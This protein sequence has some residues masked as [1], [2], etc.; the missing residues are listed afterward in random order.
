MT[1]AA[2]QPG[3]AAGLPALVKS[4]LINLLGPY[5]VYRATAPSFPPNS[6]VPLLLC[7]LVPAVE[8]AI[9]FARRRVVDVIAII[10]FAQIAAGLVI[11]LVAASATASL[12]GHAMM[13]AILGLVFAASAAIGKP[14]MTPLARQT[15]A[16]DDPARQA[17]FDSIA[18]LP[19]A[20]RTFMHLTLAWAAAL[21]LESAVLLAARRTLGNADYLL[22][23]Q[24]INYGVLAMLIWGSI[25]FGRRAMRNDP[26]WPAE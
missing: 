9:L 2:V 14:L 13:P 11:S 5:L 8:F 17:R 7:A 18:L 16:G 12:D 26:D 10:S 4:L 6:P 1:M 21:G 24:V 15:M 25:H 23:S 19:G 22:V 20:R 3:R